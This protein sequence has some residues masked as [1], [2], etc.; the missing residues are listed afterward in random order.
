MLTRFMD[1]CQSGFESEAIRWL[2]VIYTWQGPGQG[3]RYR[4]G[5]DKRD[6]N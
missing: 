5:K 1:S 3:Q 2:V 6:S 4:I